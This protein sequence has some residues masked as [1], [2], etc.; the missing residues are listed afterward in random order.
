MW[1]TAQWEGDN[2]CKVAAGEGG[3]R[4]YREIGCALSVCD[5]HIEN[6]ERASHGTIGS[7]QHVEHRKLRAAS[8]TSKE[9]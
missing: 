5:E 1:D 8:L 4:E 7:G 9:N 3:Q 6:D 2:C